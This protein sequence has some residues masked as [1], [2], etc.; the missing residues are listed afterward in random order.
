[1]FGLS[2]SVGRF[3]TVKVMHATQV[4]TCVRSASCGLVVPGKEDI[5]H[6]ASVN[7]VSVNNLAIGRRT[8]FRS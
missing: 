8:K 1:M 4:L 6:S 7:V 3:P 5:S 2:L